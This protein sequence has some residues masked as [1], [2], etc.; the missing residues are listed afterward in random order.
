MADGSA[1]FII[2]VD[3]ACACETPSPPVLLIVAIYVGIPMRGICN[4][5]HVGRWRRLA[6]GDLSMAGWYARQR[7]FSPLVRSCYWARFLV[8]CRGS[9]SSSATHPDRVG[10]LSF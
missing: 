7:P 4:M 6:H 9:S 1:R 10:G 5:R 8:R 3:S 2:A